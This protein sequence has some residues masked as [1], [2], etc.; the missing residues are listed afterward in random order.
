MTRA[1]WELNSTISGGYKVAHASSDLHSDWPQGTFQIFHLLPFICFKFLFPSNNEICC[2]FPAQSSVTNVIFTHTFI[3]FDF[4]EFVLESLL[5]EKTFF[6]WRNSNECFRI[7][8]SEMAKEFVWIYNNY[9]IIFPTFGASL[10]PCAFILKIT[11][12][13]ELFNSDAM[14]TIKKSSALGKL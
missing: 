7:F 14:V 3:Q 6:F 4:R 2:S 8:S 1:K 11:H 5:R 12:L 10:A 13:M 9:T